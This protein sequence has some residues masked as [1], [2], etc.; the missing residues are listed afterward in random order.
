MEMNAGCNLHPA[1]PRCCCT[2]RTH[3]TVGQED[4][5]KPEYLCMSGNDM[6]SVW[7]R[8]DTRN[9]IK[10]NANNSARR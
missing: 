9:D 8:P 6:F 10:G 3:G 5:N 7:H 2:R 4:L 1:P